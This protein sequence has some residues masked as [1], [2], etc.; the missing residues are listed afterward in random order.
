MFVELTIS[1]YSRNLERLFPTKPDGFLPAPGLYLGLLFTNFGAIF[2]I[3]YASNTSSF[4][5]TALITRLTPFSF[6]LLPYMIPNSW[7]KIY[8]HPHD[9][10]K[11]HLTLFRTISITS[12]ILHLKTSAVALFRNTPERTYYRHS[13]LHPFEEEHRSAIDRSTSAVGR[14]L[15]AISE[16]PVVSAV[17]VD[18]LL[19]GLT[20][21]TWAGARGLDAREMLASAVPFMR[22][23][24]REIKVVAENV[25]N[26]VKDVAEKVAEKYASSPLNR[27]K[28]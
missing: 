8:R 5:N 20:L 1:S 7:G 9:A 17:G 22:P 11:T 10:H 13:L 15:G 16:H 19:S 6:L 21:G 27:L 3:P 28:S 25:K 12:S 2:L 14:V 26:E 18:V 24:V 23:L 4:V